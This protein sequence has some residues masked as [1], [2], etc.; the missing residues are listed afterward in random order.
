MW[1]LHVVFALPG[2]PKANAHH[3]V[4]ALSVCYSA[5]PTYPPRKYLMFQYMS[6]HL[7]WN[8][9]PHSE[10]DMSGLGTLSFL[11]SLNLS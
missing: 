9:K 3:H 2:S 8:L 6:L 5:Y 10:L 1:R 4:V 11:T 7:F